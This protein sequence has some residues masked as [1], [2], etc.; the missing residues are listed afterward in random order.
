MG[1]ELTTFVVIGIRVRMTNL[2]SRKKQSAFV[3]DVI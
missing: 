2:R 1:F 3:F